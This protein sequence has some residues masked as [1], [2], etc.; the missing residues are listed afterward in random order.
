MYLVIICFN[1]PP[2]TLIGGNGTWPIIFLK[3]GSFFAHPTIPNKACALCK[4]ADCK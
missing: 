2:E 4:M 3:F 1:I